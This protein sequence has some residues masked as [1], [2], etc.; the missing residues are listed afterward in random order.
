M[1][2]K[3]K[4]KPRRHYAGLSP[5][6]KMRRLYDAKDALED[7]F[8]YEQ[9]R[10]AVATLEVEARERL[11]LDLSDKDTHETRGYIRAM[12]QVQDIHLK[13]FYTLEALYDNE[14]RAIDARIAEEER[15]ANDRDASGG[16]GEQLRPEYDPESLL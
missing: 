16:A 10:A 7:N 14:Q 12:A 6:D 3:P 15:A 2:R 13:Q 4:P 8:L 11:A 5:A 9:I 1:P